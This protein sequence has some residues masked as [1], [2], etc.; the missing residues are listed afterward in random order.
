MNSFRFFTSPL[1]QSAGLLLGFL[2]LAAGVLFVDLAPLP[3]QAAG[4]I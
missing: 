1:R 4:T 2:A 3:A